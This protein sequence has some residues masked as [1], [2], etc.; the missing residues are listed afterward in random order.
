MK[1]IALTLVSALTV[2]S[3][4]ACGGNSGNGNNTSAANG[5]KPAASE[6]SE[7]PAGKEK[8]KFYTFKAST[9]EEPMFQAVKAYNESQDKVEVEYESLVQNSNSTDFMKKLDILVAGGEAVDVFMTGSEEELLERASRGV[10]EPLNSYLEKEAVKPEEEYNK[11]IKLNSDIYGLMTSSTQWFT[12]FNKDHLEKAGLELPKMG[13][14]WDDFRGYAKKLTMDGHYGTYF[15]TWGEYADVIAY[16]ERP[17][18]Q[19]DADMKPIFDDPSFKYFFE[20]RRA[21]EQEDKSVEPYADVLASNYHVLQQFFAGNASML[22]VPSYAVRAGLNLEKFPHEFQMMYAPVP[23]SVDA[24][25]VGM[26]NISGG[27]L[28]IGAKSEHKEA[29]YDFIRW[30]SKEAYKYTKEIPSFKGVDGAA[31]INDF[32]KDNTDLID[33]TSLANT[34]FDPN[35]KMPDA[36][37]VPYGAELKKIVEDGFSSYMLDNRDFDE[38]KASMTDEVNKVVEANK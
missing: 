19:L 24:T 8:I 35:N 25:E 37:S 10:V 27:G 18:P 5:N 3:L 7:K 12:V 20:L 31:L 38:V 29:A 16:T 32:F 33:T 34:L 15:H 26:T 1:K 11:V 9:E 13:W 17:N 36:F 30:I 28:A 6:Q 14:T 4:A 22:V 21:M 23:R 2:F